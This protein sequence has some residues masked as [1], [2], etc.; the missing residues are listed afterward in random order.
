MQKK[1]ISIYRVLIA[2]TLMT[3]S[4]STGLLLRIVS[5]GFLLDFNRKYIVAPSSRLILFLI[6]V[7]LFI[8]KEKNFPAQQ[9]LYTFNHNSFLDIIIVTALGLTNT[10]FFL[11][12][13]TI[14]YLPITL[15]ALAIGTLYIPFKNQQV[16][17]LSFF[18]KAAERAQKERFSIFA[19]SEGVHTFIHGI[20]PFNKGIYHLAVNAALPIVPVYLHIPENVNSLEGYIFERGTVT[21]EVLETIETSS[22][23]LEK[24]PGHVENVRSLFI[25]KF[26]YEHY[27]Q[28]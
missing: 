19:S 10:R 25:N 11:S 22:W 20:A 18:R 28:S 15:S 5:F 9:V 12:V 13:R 7:K 27:R 4:G 14:K 21:V 3:I 23:N 2:F 17:R 6:G 1:I 16:K 8:R 26:N 24:L